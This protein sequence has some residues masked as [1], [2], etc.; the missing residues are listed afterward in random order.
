LEWSHKLQVKRKRQN[1]QQEV[2]QHVPENE[3]I[4]EDMDLDMDIENIQFPD[5][6]QRLQESKEIAA[7][8]ASSR[9]S[10]FRGRILHCA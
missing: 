6:E 8:I 2:E 4:L 9:R 5:D 1:S 7:E 10:I 3:I